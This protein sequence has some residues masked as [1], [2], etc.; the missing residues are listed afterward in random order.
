MKKLIKYGLVALAALA[1]VG[2]EEDDE[3]VG[4]VDY[5]PATPQGV[6]SVT[7]DGEVYVYWNGIYDSDVK[8]YNIYRSFNEYTGYSRIGSVS[9][10]NNPNLDL[11]IYEYIDD[12]VANGTTYFY[13]VTSVDYA[14]Q[15]SE[16]SAESVF[17]TPRPQG[18]APIFPFTVNP[19]AGGFNLASGFQVAYDSPEADVWVDSV[20]GIYYL[21]VGNSLT[22]IQDLG[23]TNSFDDI[24]YAP[25]FGWSS[26]GFE[27][28][29]LGHTYVIWTDDDHF[30]KMRALS[31][32][33]SGSITF[34]WAYQTA[35]SNLELSPPVRPAHDDSFA[36]AASTQ[37]MKLLK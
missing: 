27:E 14:N 21:N 9:A 23:F 31:L 24:S 16:L 37:T 22:D 25:E 34:E 35:P 18:Q 19:S 29:I 17:D 20:N 33:G 3:I 12:N 5:V 6:S 8:R 26:L 13:A 2:C 32:N 30:A 10:A 28:I 36:N 4:V 1:L 15:E 11:L 7:G